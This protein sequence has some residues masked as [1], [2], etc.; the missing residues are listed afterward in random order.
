[1]QERRKRGRAGER[2]RARGENV[3]ERNNTFLLFTV[4][5]FNIIHYSVYR[6]LLDSGRV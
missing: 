6:I 2:K 5:I 1:M 3:G 4:V